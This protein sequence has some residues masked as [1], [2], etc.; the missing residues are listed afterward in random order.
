MNKK[1][2]SSKNFSKKFNL[3]LAIIA[4]ILGLLLIFYPRIFELVVAVILIFW[5]LQIIILLF[6][7]YFYK[8]RNS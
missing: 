2:K 4:I 8:N 7:D 6:I 1:E 5:G 3:I